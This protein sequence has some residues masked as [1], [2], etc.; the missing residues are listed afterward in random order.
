M[1]LL[2]QLEGVAS[3]F[4]PLLSSVGTERPTDPVPARPASVACINFLFS[5]GRSVRRGFFGCEGERETDVLST[6]SSFVV[7]VVLILCHRPQ[8]KRDEK[9]RCCIKFVACRSV[10]GFRKHLSVFSVNPVTCS[11]KCGITSKCSTLRVH[12][13]TN[14]L[15]GRVL[16][17]VCVPFW[18]LVLRRLSSRVQE[19]NAQGNLD[20]G[21]TIAGFLR[22]G[23]A[24]MAHGAV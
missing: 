8:N 15:L 3:D 4:P 7:V 21:C 18:C 17:T 14:P 9:Y 6:R 22:V 19:F 23:R 13:S 1:F 24:M 12:V 11:F 10:S 5:D 16:G 2:L 20:K